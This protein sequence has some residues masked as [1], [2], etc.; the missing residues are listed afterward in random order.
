MAEEGTLHDAF[1][2]ELRDLYD[3]ERQLTRAL[4]RLA[5][6]AT[7][8]SLREAFEL[9]LL[10][11]QEQMERLEQVF[12]LLEEKVRGRHCEGISGIIEEGKATMQKRFAPGTM[13]ACLIA[14]G[15]RAEHYEIAA[16]GT[17]ISWAEAMGQDDVV[18][19]LGQN[20]DEEQAADEKLSNLAEGGINH[21]A[22][23]RSNSC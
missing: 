2:D 6:T 21:D 9:H 15:R 3:C 13:D 5:E 11:T 8:P 12:D 10:E 22:A 17:L 18:T 14:A 20:L 16:Y 4:T 23:D 19:L 1:V 7:A